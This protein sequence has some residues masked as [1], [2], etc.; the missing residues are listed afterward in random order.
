MYC[1]KCGKQN[2]DK[3]AV[4]TECGTVLKQPTQQPVAQK[5]KKKHTVRNILLILLGVFVFFWLIGTFGGDDEN[6]DNPSNSTIQAGQR[7]TEEGHIGDYIVVV[8]DSILA[9]QNDNDVLIVTYSFT[10]N[11]DDS[12]AFMYA[13]TDKLFQNGVELGT[14]YGSWGIDDVYNFDNRSKEIKPG[15]TLDVQCAYELN[16]TTTDVEVEITEWISFNDDKIT[17]TIKL[18]PEQ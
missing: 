17:S 10:N 13:I 2:D 15:V 1:M 8:K 11:S 4:C 3:N 12:K 18:V 6:T 9:K 7:E 5:P 14:V 16:D